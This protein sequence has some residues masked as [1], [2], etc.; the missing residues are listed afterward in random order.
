M[1]R[2]GPVPHGKTR[3]VEDSRVEMTQIVLPNDTN[4]LGNIL[5]G[6][7]M[8][9]IDL[10]AAIVAHRH[11]RR[12]VVTASMDHLHFLNPIR[13]G[14][15]VILRGHINHVS[16]SSM[17]IEVGVLS[18]DIL[19]GEERH[20]CTAFLTF[21]AI[22]DLGQPIAVPTLSLRTTAERRRFAEAAARREAR[23]KSAAEAKRQGRIDVR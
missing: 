1:R 12:K 18:E 2:K 16:K 15:I 19:T 3:L 5:G 23:L 8:H 7:V 22:D 4:P 20:C 11:C 6:T 14:Q 10:C 13:M 9:L 21:V 17:E